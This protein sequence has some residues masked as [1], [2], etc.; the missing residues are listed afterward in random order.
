MDNIDFIFSEEQYNKLSEEYD[1]ISTLNSPIH[2]A[3]LRSIAKQIQQNSFEMPSDLRIE[4]YTRINS[5]VQT[6]SILSTDKSISNPIMSNPFS[7]IYN[8]SKIAQE[9]NS[10]FLDCPYKKICKKTCNILIDC[11]TLI[12]EH[13]SSKTIKIY[14]HI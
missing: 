12:S 4:I 3:K 7:I 9:L 2:I 1:K 13:F 8:L 10:P 6:L 11:I 14:R 5:C